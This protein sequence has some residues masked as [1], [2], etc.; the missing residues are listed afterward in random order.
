[1]RDTWETRYTVRKGDRNLADMRN[2]GKSGDIEK[3]GVS[4]KTGEPRSKGVTE[5]D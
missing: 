2:T 1:M 3:S 5:D 4:G